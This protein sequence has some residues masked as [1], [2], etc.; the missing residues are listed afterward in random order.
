MPWTYH[1][2]NGELWLDGA[3]IGD[4]YSGHGV[5]RNNPVKQEIPNV[6]PIPIGHYVIGPAYTHPIKGPLVMRLTSLSNTFGRS[7]FLIHG[8]SAAHTG[9]ASDGCIILPHQ[10]RLQVATSDDNELEVRT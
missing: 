1:Q 9:E 2:T 3:L 8:D 6:G 4:G 10:T 5:G 7:G